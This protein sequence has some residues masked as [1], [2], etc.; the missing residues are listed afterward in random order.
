MARFLVLEHGAA[1]AV[2]GAS[3]APAALR[4]AARRLGVPAGSVDDVTPSLA[5][6][7]LEPIAAGCTEVCEGGCG[8]F[9]S[10]EDGAQAFHVPVGGGFAVYCLPCARRIADRASEVR[11]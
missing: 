6:V 2:V 7:A 11:P 4:R 1:V 5:A 10:D 9:L 3:D 8:T